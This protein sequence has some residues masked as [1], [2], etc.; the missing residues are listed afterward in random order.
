VDRTLSTDWSEALKDRAAEVHL[1][2]DADDFLDDLLRAMVLDALDTVAQA[3]QVLNQNEEWAGAMDAGYRAIRD[4]FHP[5][6]ADAILRWW[7]DGVTET[8]AGRPFATE[9]RGRQ[10]LMT[11]AYLAGADGPPVAVAG[12][13]GRLI[14]SSSSQYFEITCR[15]GQHTRDVEKVVRDR[16]MRRRAEGVYPDDR[17]VTVVVA[18]A[19]GSFPSPAAQPEIAAGKEEGS[20]LAAGVTSAPIRL[21]AADAGPRGELVA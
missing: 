2:M 21:V 1:A 15:P 5:V 18:D 13:T 6:A 9:L 4:A 8:E 7:R 19:I 17:G 10:A 11:V 12:T 16:L 3:V 14:V 20:D